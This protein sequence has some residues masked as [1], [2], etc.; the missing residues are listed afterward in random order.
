[1][2]WKRT[3]PHHCSHATTNAP[4]VNPQLE[5]HRAATAAVTGAATTGVTATGAAAVVVQATR[6]T[7]QVAGP[8][9]QRQDEV[10]Q[11]KDF[12]HFGASQGAHVLMSKDLC[13]VKPPVMMLSV[14]LDGS[15]WVHC[16]ADVQGNDGRASQLE[17]C[18][19]M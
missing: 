1:M 12:T 4:V 19:F 14:H 6:V 10:Q 2:R 15:K 5:R 16:G 7:A 8:R 13:T 18:F 11:T 3:G 9:V 17:A